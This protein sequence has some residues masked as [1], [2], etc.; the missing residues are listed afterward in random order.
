MLK[1]LLKNRNTLIKNLKGNVIDANDIKQKNCKYTNYKIIFTIL[2]LSTCLFLAGTI[3][4]LLCN[5]L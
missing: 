5:L 3:Y 1:E 4:L 2:G